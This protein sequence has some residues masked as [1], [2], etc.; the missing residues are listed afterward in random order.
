MNKFF[1]DNTRLSVVLKSDRGHRLISAAGTALSESSSPKSASHLLKGTDNTG[2]TLL[3]SPQGKQPSTQL[4]YSC[5][6]YIDTRDRALPLALYQGGILDTFLGGYILGIR[7]HHLL[8]MRFTSPDRFSPFMAG[9]LNTYAFCNGDPINYTDP[10]GHVRIPALAKLATGV[11]AKKHA[12]KFGTKNDVFRLK[13]GEYK[14]VIYQW[15]D[16]KYEKYLNFSTERYKQ[17]VQ[18]LSKIPRDSPFENKILENHPELKLEA[19]YHSYQHAFAEIERLGFKDRRNILPK[20]FTKITKWRKAGFFD[21]FGDMPLE[22]ALMALS[23]N[24]NATAALNT[25]SH[26]RKVIETV[27]SVRNLNT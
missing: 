7:L 11:L 4:V 26:W 6:G 1:Y 12:I 15:T 8:L 20:H 13:N 24:P 2:S 16:R 22:D 25:L 14:K 21:E 3:L 27:A 10:S 23:N 5:Y 19:K 9:G 17:Y 18:E